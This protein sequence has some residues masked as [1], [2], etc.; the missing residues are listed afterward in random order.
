[1]LIFTE[2]TSNVYHPQFVGSIDRLIN[3]LTHEEL[4]DLRPDL[5]I[6]LGGMVISKKIKNF[7]RNHQPNHHW[8]IDPIRA[9]D[10]YHCL[11][12]HI[13]LRPSVFFSLMQTDSL[14]LKTDFQRKWK[15]LDEVRSD[16]HRKY[17][18][19]AVHSDLK[20]MEALL[21]K[22]PNEYRLQLG[23]SAVVRYMQLFDNQQHRTHCNRGTSGIDGSTSTAIGAALINEEPTLLISGDLSFFYD[24]N[25]LWNNYIKTNFR[26]VII[27]NSGGGIFKILPGPSKTNALPYF[28]TP[29]KLT[30][31]QLC[32][33]YQ[34]DY[35]KASTTEDLERELDTFF[36][37]NQKPKLLE[38]F[39][40]HDI[41]D[42]V[43]KTYFEKIS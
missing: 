32:E 26:I 5:L 8:H 39:T 25:A 4:V 16:R 7:L 36:N 2:T 21:N 34:I 35:H 11:T 29:H 3:S 6:T 27:N 13:T 23:N 30:A 31:M 15:N 9:F 12:N 10:T 33:M 17:L 43:L 24:S 19:S 40:P 28:T 22:I 18:N 20:A 41:N 38:I 42:Q 1:V 37:V 14:M